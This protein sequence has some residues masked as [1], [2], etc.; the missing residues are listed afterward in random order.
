MPEAMPG[1]LMLFAALAAYALVAALALPA[2]GAP[3]QP[4]ARRAQRLAG[5]ALAAALV[6]HTLALALRWN[7]LGHGPFTTMHEILS[8]SLWSHG[9]GLRAGVVVGGRAARRAAGGAA[10]VGRARRVAAD[11][12]CTR[13][14]PAAHLR[15]AAALPACGG[16]QALPRAAAG[17]GG[18]RHGAGALRRTAW[19]AR[20][21]AKGADDRRLDE[22][23]HRF[24]AYALVADTLMLIVGAVWAQ[25]AWGRYWAWDPLESWAFASWLALVMA[26]HARAT[27]RP[28]PWQ[29]GLWLAGSFALAFLTFFGVPFLSTAPHKG[30]I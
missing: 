18:A 12:R 7:A 13:R 4:V 24:A 2:A 14:P 22:L 25:D 20:R 26:L 28:P 15:D 19:G 8:S 30:A 29:F 27:L 21:F 16:G 17:R 5:L 11:G 23:A 1:S 3:W 10:G 6:L 9:A